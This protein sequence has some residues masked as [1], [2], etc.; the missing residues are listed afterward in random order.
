[1]PISTYEEKKQ[2]LMGLFVLARRNYLPPNPWT[3]TSTPHY[4][5]HIYKVTNVIFLP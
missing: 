1:M 3:I 5:V 2:A 4:N